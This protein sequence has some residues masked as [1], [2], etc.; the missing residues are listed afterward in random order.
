MI[1]VEQAFDKT[2]K[3]LEKLTETVQQAAKQGERIDQ[4]ER[5][6]FAVLLEIEKHFL[7]MN[8]AQSIRS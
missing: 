7:W 6:I 2:Q 5:N 8:K 3:L 1:A 4:V